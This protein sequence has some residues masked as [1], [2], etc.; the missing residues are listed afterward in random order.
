[1]NHGLWVLLR[2]RVWGW[3]RRLGR[4]LA[5][6]RGVLLIAFGA[7]VFF[8]YA[9]MW[10]V[11]AVRP[12][13]HTEEVRRYGA[14]VLAAYC[15]MELLVS[16]AEGISFSM[17]EVNLLFPAPLSRRQLLAYKLMGTVGTSLL[18]T[19][20][21]TLFLGQYALTFEGAVVGL[22]LATLFVQ[23][24]P[25][26][27][28]LLASSL[29]AR[30]YNRRRKAVLALLAALAAVALITGLRGRG[31]SE[32][33]EALEQSEVAQVVLAP[34]R[35]FVH[36]F[37]AEELWPDLVQWAALGLLVNACLV[38]VVFALD[39]HYLETSAAASERTYARLQRLRSGG[40]GLAGAP[41]SGW[42]RLRIPALPAWGGIGPVAWRQLVTAARSPRSL[43][44]ALFVTA[45]IGYTAL[46]SS[47]SPAEPEAAPV[48]ALVIVFMLALFIPQLLPFDFRADIDRMDVLKTLPLPAWRLVVGQLL[49]PVLLVSVLQGLLL[50][51]LATAGGR[52]D[53][54]LL[55][56]A[57]FLLPVN[58]LLF[59]IDNLLF[60]L[61]PTRYVQ[62]GPGDLQTLG[63][64]MVVWLAKLVV[65]VLV[66]IVAS[67]LGTVAF[68]LAGENLIAGTAVVWLVLWGAL[69][70]LVPL[71]ALAFRRFDV[72]RD[73]P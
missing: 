69:A 29:G 51:V 11:G 73:R 58:F 71:I 54:L 39:A 40:P 19:V 32:L 53:P 7:L 21:L 31:G 66:G 9:V 36:A 17:A 30:A 64:Q 16:S 61:F 6:V 13:Q 65:F 26:T 60:L 20:L 44:V 63:R 24:V 14:L 37:T 15:V 50:L 23:L 28:A 34:F 35:W 49:V 3:L 47:G 1:V 68:L 72:A 18:S 45:M 67:L 43:L 27:L 4:S 57:A 2:L 22:L 56:G 59:G 52:S 8:P 12:G 48:M 5:S 33:V 41:A 42:G 62:A 70:G 38:G 25:I 46:G 55:G 10:L